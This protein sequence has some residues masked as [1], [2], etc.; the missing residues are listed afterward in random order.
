[1]P[2]IGL[3]EELP[4]WRAMVAHLDAA[5]VYWDD[6]SLVG[7]LARSCTPTLHIQAAQ[8]WDD[9]PLAAY[10]DAVKSGCAPNTQRFVLGSHSHAGVVYD[11]FANT[12]PSKLL[13]DYLD[14][15]LK[16]EPVDI[17]SVPNVQFYLSNEGKWH[18]APAWR[19]SGA[20]MELFF[21][22]GNALAAHAP[23]NTSTLGYSV[24][25]AADDPCDAGF[26][27]WLQMRSEPTE[28]PIDIVGR[29][30]IVLYL[31]VDTPDGDVFASLYD[32]SSA[33]DYSL[34][35]LSQ[36]RLRYRHSYSQPERMT[37]GAVE[38]VRIEL[39]AVA[40]RIVA[41]HH[42]ELFLAGA[43]CGAAENPNTGGSISDEEST[44]RSTTTIFSDPTR[45][46]RIRLPTL[47]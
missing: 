42:L 7:K 36:L 44:L 12:V 38:A 33:G 39:P 14:R 41:G 6:R 37:V 22:G 45:P 24:D 10:L 32:V 31:S 25:P 23:V 5:S 3:G 29:A 27:G 34:V 28:T 26:G 20:T 2:P 8:E 43:S 13:R 30:E 47:E 17:D 16:D 21:A 46:S 11:P 35:H 15:Y 19:A 1:M 18:A 4:A 40:T 9:D